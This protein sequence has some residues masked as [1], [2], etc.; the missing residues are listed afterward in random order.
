MCCSHLHV[1]RVTQ[2]VTP[3]PG[4]S[5]RLDRGV[6]LPKP[7]IGNLA[8]HMYVLAR[9]S[10]GTC[11]CRGGPHISAGREKWTSGSSVHRADAV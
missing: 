11:A 9:R 2:H 3:Q 10:A 1:T 8:P 6:T 5:A 4:S 7:R